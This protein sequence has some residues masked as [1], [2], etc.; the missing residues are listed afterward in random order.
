MQQ[1][2]KDVFASTPFLENKINLTGYTQPTLCLDDIDNG[3]LPDIVIYDWEYG[4]PNPTESQNWLLEILEKTSAFV[5]VYS[6]VRD[7]IP[8]F[9]NKS[10]FDPYSERFQLFLKGSSGN[11]IFSSE[12]YIYQYIMTMLSSTPS[13]ILNSHKIAFK[14]NGYLEAPTDILYLENIIG[15][16]VLLD[17][18]KN[19]DSL[20]DEAIEDIFSNINEIIYLD[21]AKKILIYPQAMM[22]MNKFKPT[23]SLSIKEVSKRFGVK[24]LSDVY[25]FGIAKI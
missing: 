22:F 25:E 21:E 14:Q 10:K 15:R 2:I 24:T 6:H 20:S 12:E 19:I 18:I 1:L 7:D 17:K 4:M 16:E 3:K 9:L 8:F 11:S 23:F 13:L 5:F